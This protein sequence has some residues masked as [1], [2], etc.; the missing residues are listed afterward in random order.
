MRIE[1]FFWFVDFKFFLIKIFWFAKIHF[2]A[3][4]EPEVESV[5]PF[6]LC[7]QKNN[8]AWL[9]LMFMKN[10]HLKFIKLWKVFSKIFQNLLKVWFKKKNSK[11]FRNKSEQKPFIIYWRC[12]KQRRCWAFSEWSAEKLRFAKRNRKL[13]C[14]D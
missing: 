12:F 1:I 11:Y 9:L 14:N 5:A 2:F 3:C 13:R 6:A 8:F 4:Q 10:L 7:L